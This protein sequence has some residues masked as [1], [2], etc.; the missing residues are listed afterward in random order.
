MRV[1]VVLDVERR[2][3][4]ARLSGT[5]SCQRRHH[6]PVFELERAESEGHEQL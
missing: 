4:V 6:D 1:D 5:H 2:R 3:H